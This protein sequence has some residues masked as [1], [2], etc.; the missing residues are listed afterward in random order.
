MKLMSFE[1]AG[2]ASFGV[3]VGD[4]VFDLQHLLEGR[5]ADLKSLLEG[6]GIALA[7]AAI[8]GRT[9]DLKLADVRFLPVIPNPGKIWCAGLNY[10]EH[11]R[12]TGREI[13]EKP[14][15]F[16]RVADSQ[17]G[18]DE[19]IP[20]PPESTRLDYEGEIAVIIGKGGRRIREEDA[21]E[22]IAGYACYNDGSVRDWQL[23]T[24]QW[25]PGK[26]FWRTGGFG[27]WMVTADEIEPGARLSLVTRLNGEEVQRATTDMMLH[28]IPRQ[29]AYA[30]TVAPLRPGDVF[31]TGTPGG[32]GAKRTPSLWMK[33]GDVVEVEVERVGILRN[34]IVD[35]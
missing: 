35:E 13:S 31:V 7:A 2:K 21:W 1:H 6:D 9:P 28:S 32:I 23:H 14:M 4:G 8:E 11:V 27:P 17:V 16:L 30:S 18:H 29:I 34:T 10:G 33:P 5:F 26:N 25:A 20:R 24:A 12:E 15:F 22:H 19:A 3:A